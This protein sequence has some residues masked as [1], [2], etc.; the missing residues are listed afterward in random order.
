MNKKIKEEGANV[1]IILAGLSALLGIAD[2]EDI[3]KNLLVHDYLI[4]FC[5]IL[6][7]KLFISLKPEFIFSVVWIFVILEIYLDY[8]ITKRRPE[9]S[10]KKIDVEFEKLYKKRKKGPLKTFIGFI[11]DIILNLRFGKQLVLYT[12]FNRNQFAGRIND[13]GENIPPT[14]DYGCEDFIT[15]L[16]KINDS[17]KRISEEYRFVKNK[18]ALKIRS[19]VAEEADIYGDFN[20]IAFKVQ[21]HYWLFALYPLKLIRW[22]FRNSFIFK[23]L[24][25]ILLILIFVAILYKSTSA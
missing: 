16:V 8:A 11:V 1:S 23:I 2:A 13:Q 5:T 24:I 10:E 4:I 6:K 20:E 21:E 15:R 3:L 25:Y 17:N 19:Y 9:I 18:I 7:R 14:E 22:L 12:S